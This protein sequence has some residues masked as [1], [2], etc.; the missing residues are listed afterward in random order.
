MLRNY[1][2][3]IFKTHDRGNVGENCIKIKTDQ[4]FDRIGIM[5]VLKIR[6]NRSWGSKS[7][8]VIDL[9]MKNKISISLNAYSFLEKFA[10][11]INKLEL[12]ESE[13]VNPLGFL[14]EN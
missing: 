9:S 11:Y 12:H 10:S 8:L 5:A 14:I 7:T 4:D 6:W 2:K 3:C 13:E 1:F